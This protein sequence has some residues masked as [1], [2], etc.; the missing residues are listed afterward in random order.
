M[1]AENLPS[2]AKGDAENLPFV[3]KKQADNLAA[4]VK[5][6]EKN[7][8]PFVKGGEGGFGL[9]ANPRPIWD[10]PLSMGVLAAVLFVPLFIFR[11]L[12]PLDFWWWMSANIAVL[13]LA[14]GAID[15]EY[16][17]S[18]A[19]DARSKAGRKILLGI[20][21]A[22]ALYGIFWVGNR[23]SRALFSFAGGDI[24]AV[25][26]F[27]SGASLF[28]IVLLMAFW[29][30]PGEELFWRAFLQRRW[31]ARLGGLRGFFAVTALY[32]LVHAGS[33]NP[34]LVLAAGVCGLFWGAL[35]LATGSF[36]LVAVSHTLWDLAVFILFP[37]G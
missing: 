28:R 11:R 12:G 23:A 35:Y 33:G 10:H 36:L 30:G 29:I 7:S 3:I 13:V 1:E 32:A 31:Q 6:D 20:L 14:G 18:I 9:P 22:A 34:M 8:P 4:F 16:F 37:F 19:A 21:S 2:L 15:K 27:K 17:R 24:G 5:A 25:Y 26:D